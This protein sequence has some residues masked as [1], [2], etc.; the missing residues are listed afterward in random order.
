VVLRKL[1]LVLILIFLLALALRF[2]YFPNN[3]YFGIDQ[4]RDAFVSQSIIHGD[5]KIIGPPTS[6]EG[7]FHGPF[8]YYIFA[9]IYFFS[10]G[11]PEAV[12][13]F[14]RIVN[15]LGVFIVFFIAK[16]IFNRRA[17]LIAAFLYAISF[18][19]TQFAIYLNH[20]SLAVISVLL[21]FLGWAL[22]I[23]KKNDLGFLLAVIALGLS[24]QFEFAETYLGLV[25]LIF[26]GVSFRQV[27]KVSKR[28]LFS[29]AVGFLVCI[30]T[31]VLTE[32]K[33]GFKTFKILPQVLGGGSDSISILQRVVTFNTINLRTIEYNLVSFENMQILTAIIL[34]AGVIF[35]FKKY[36]LQ[37]IFLLIWFFSG[38]L[39]YFKDT[40]VLP[41]YY[42]LAG[43]TAALLVFAGF[44]I[45]EFSTKSRLLLIIL[46]VPI[47]SNYLLITSLNHNGSLPDFNV[48]SGMLL[49]DQRKVLDYVYEKAG[50]QEFSVYGLTMP[51]YINMT[52][53][54]L[55][56]WY[57]SQKYG[58]MPVWGGEN[59]SGYYGY[60]KVERANSKLPAIRFFI[61]E[62]T[63]GIPGYFV[64]GF[65]KEED[66]FTEI[67]EE[68]KFGEIVVQHRRSKPL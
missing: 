15:A 56:E 53:A 17:G 47:I 20:P 44:L 46:L 28:I 66:I 26:L 24:V 9:P 41:L 25:F 2:L 45:T 6:A 13:A 10:G 14:L 65:K 61:V 49:S 43:S 1:N 42:H 40:A 3:I 5:L 50:G 27:R 52:W 48:Q 32:I 51:L 39:P 63:R 19:Q 60:L 4:A 68:K 64:E 67:I 37:I 31:F 7:L 16:A 21:F 57:G 22:F 18:E 34:L 58:Y 55:F 30:S 62:P 59:A 29:S 35:Y 36:R 8:Y 38:N 54:Y 23:F 33:F 11:N 12:S